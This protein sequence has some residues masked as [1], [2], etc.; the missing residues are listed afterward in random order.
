MISHVNNIVAGS[1]SEIILHMNHIP[2]NANGSP[3][4]RFIAT[5]FAPPNHPNV[6]L[7]YD[8][9]PTHEGRLKKILLQDRG[10]NFASAIS[11]KICGVEG[12]GGV[13]K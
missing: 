2:H 13:G 4:D 3:Q 7:D 5:F 12:M 1:A 8:D 10:R 9:D 6:V 11:S